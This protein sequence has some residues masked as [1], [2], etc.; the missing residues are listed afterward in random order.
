ME[1]LNNMKSY[2]YAIYEDTDIPKHVKIGK[3]LDVADRLDG[4]QTGNPNKLKIAAVIECKSEQHA[5]AIESDL[6][7]IYSYLHI[8]GEWFKWHPDI[9]NQFKDS[10]N[11]SNTK[12]TRDSLIL[13]SL[14]EDEQTEFNSD[15]FPNCYFYPHLAAQIMTNYEDAQKLKSP[16][17]TM[18]YPTK[19][20]H[21]LVLPNGKVIPKLN[22]VFISGRKHQE[23]LDLKRFKKEQKRNSESQMLKE[24]Y[25]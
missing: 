1:S 8:R 13:S 7:R 23:N 15:A 3:A 5:Y 22:T 18:T 17:R 19:G 21:M 20:K 9:L 11:V 10:V 6:H 4:L 24:T 16:W 2:V 25:E 12:K 14:W